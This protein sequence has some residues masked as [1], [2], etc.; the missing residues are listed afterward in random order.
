MDF[1][2]LSLRRGANNPSW[3]GG[4]HVGSK[5]YVWVRV[6][7]RYVLEHRHM[8]SQHLGRPLL[9]SELVHHENEIRSDNRIENFVLTTRARHIV[10]HHPILYERRRINR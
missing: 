9:T 10:E 4:R 5:G 8:M 2:Y 1:S 6:D 3:K 7:G